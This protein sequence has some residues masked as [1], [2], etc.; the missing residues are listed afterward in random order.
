LAQGKI[1]RDRARTSPATVPVVSGVFP[2]RA[3]VQSLSSGT[4]VVVVEVE[5][6]VVVEG[7]VPGAA[8]V[9]TGVSPTTALQAVIAKPAR[10]ERNTDLMG[11]RGQAIAHYGLNR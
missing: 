2:G 6:V 11:E 5:D 4:V 3:G 7:T 10:S 9:A 1:S 8:I